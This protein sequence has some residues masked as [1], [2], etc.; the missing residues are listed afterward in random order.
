MSDLYTLFSLCKFE[1]FFGESGFV[2]VLDLINLFLKQILWSKR[3]YAFLQPNNINIA[4]FFYGHV[5]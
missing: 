3:S 5:F 2:F 4:Y 1:K